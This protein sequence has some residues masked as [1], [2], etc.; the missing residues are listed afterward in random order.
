MKLELLL[1]FALAGSFCTITHASTLVV[2]SEVYLQTTTGD[3]VSTKATDTISEGKDALDAAVTEALPSEEAPADT[4]VAVQKTEAPSPHSEVPEKSTEAS[5]H[6][7]GLVTETVGPS[8]PNEATVEQ[9]EATLAHTETSAEK[10]ETTAGVTESP[11]EN[12]MAEETAETES[13]PE[14]DPEATKKSEVSETTLIDTAVEPG[15]KTDPHVIETEKDEVEVEDSD[16]M[17][18]GQ[19]VGIVFGALVSVVIIIAVI[20]V[21]VRRMGQYSP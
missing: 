12:T 14:M 2:P 3:T 19:V 9:T 6:N 4:E 17:S 7:E 10:P 18:T 20:V 16:G 8:F 15:L 13:T 5:S 21:V 1:L 11:A